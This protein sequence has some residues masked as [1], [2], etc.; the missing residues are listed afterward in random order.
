[1]KLPLFQVH[2]HRCTLLPP[3]VPNPLAELPD[4][5]P[6]VKS[7]CAALDSEVFRQCREGDREIDI[8]M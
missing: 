8:N 6:D 2:E 7:A 1:M 3:D 4:V 5:D